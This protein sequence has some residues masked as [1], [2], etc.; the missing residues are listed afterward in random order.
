MLTWMNELMVVGD[1]FVRVQKQIEV[2]RY[3]QNEIG[4]LTGVNSGLVVKVNTLRNAFDMVVQ[5]WEAGEKHGIQLAVRLLKYNFEELP[6]Y[7]IDFINQLEII[8]VFAKRGT[9]LF[10][11]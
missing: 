11:Y 7:E 6:H 5:S 8:K 1:Q 2:L 4:E 9:I 3:A 10:L